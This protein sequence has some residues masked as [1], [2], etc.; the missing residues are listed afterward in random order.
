MKCFKLQES[1]SNYQEPIMDWS[2][3]QIDDETEKTWESLNSPEE[4]NSSKVVSNDSFALVQSIATLSTHEED[5]S[6]EKVKTNFSVRHNRIVCEVNSKMK[7]LRRWPSVKDAANYFKVTNRKIS[8]ACIKGH[9]IDGLRIQYEDDVPNPDFPDEI[10]KSVPY[11]DIRLI[12]VSNYGRVRG[13]KGGILKKFF[14]RKRCYV[15][16]QL[17]HQNMGS[18]RPVDR[19]V[20]AAFLGDSYSKIIH[21]D[22]DTTNNKSDNLKYEV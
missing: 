16:V 18:K 21:I 11:D 5:D 10:W 12:H 13:T 6:K 9:L 20:A 19:L 17:K 8:D 22:G 7:I 15:Y 14:K 4:N 3:F 2:F 1:I